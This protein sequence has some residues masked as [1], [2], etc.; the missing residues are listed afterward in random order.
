[1]SEGL[2]PASF[3][4][5]GLVDQVRRFFSSSI[6]IYKNFAPDA[7]YE[8]QTFSF[9]AHAF[10]F[11]KQ[12]NEDVETSRTENVFCSSFEN[13]NEFSAFDFHG[14]RRFQVLKINMNKR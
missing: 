6:D 1:M 12:P 9:V 8:G 3:A 13:D 4:V 14:E 11:T 2:S 7:N 10:T 5:E